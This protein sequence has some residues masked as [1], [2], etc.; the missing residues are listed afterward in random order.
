[1]FRSQN[2]SINKGRSER[3]VVFGKLKKGSRK[4]REYIDISSQGKN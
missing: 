2:R 1:M 3:E 4:E